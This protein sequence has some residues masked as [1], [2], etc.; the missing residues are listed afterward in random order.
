MQNL[1]VFVA[2]FQ[3]IYKIMRNIFRNVAMLLALSA[4][5]LT[6]SAHCTAGITDDNGDQDRLFNSGWK[7]IRDSIPGAELPGY[8]DSDWEIVDLPHDYSFMDLPGEDSD[9]QIGPFSKKSPGNGNSTGHVIGG[10]GWYRKQF[11]LEKG[12]QDK[13]AVLKFDGVYMES[14]IWVNGEKLYENRNGYTPFLVDITGAL[15]E[16]GE[17]NTIAVKVE[18]KGRNSRWYSG[19]GIYRDVHLLLDH[20]LHVAPWGVYIRTPKVTA[21]TVLAAIQV[22]LQNDFDTDMEVGITI[23]FLDSQDQIVAS[24]EDIVAVPGLGHV[25]TEKELEIKNPILWSLGS[26]YLYTAEITVE[27]DHRVTD[28]YRQPF[29]V[30]TIDISAEHG[31]LLNGEPLLLKGGCL[32]HDNGLLGAAA[33]ERAEARKVELIKASGY[34]AIRIA[35]NPPSEHLLDA[36]DRQGMLVINEFTDMWETYKNPQDYSRFFR[37]DWNKD[38]THMILRDRN[39]PSI[40]MWSIGN[41]ILKNSVADA[42]RIGG[43]LAERVRELDDTRFITEAVSHIFTPEGWDKSGPVFEL[44]DAGGYNYLFDRYEDDHALFPQRIMYAS[45]SFPNKA[46]ETW[47]QVEQHPYVIGD[48]VW[49]AI[50][51]IGEVLVGNSTYVPEEQHAEFSLPENIVL[52]PGFSIWDYM[53]SMPSNWPNYIAWCGDLDITGQ[54]KPQSLFRD[55]LWDSSPIEINVHEPIPEGMAENLSGWGWPKEYPRWY[56][57]GSEGNPLEVRVFTKAHEVRLILNGRI[58]G[59]K[60]LTDQD[61]Y[62]ASFM[63]PYEAGELKAIALENGLEVASKTYTTPGEPVAVSLS[64]DRARITADRSDLAYVLIEVVDEEGRLV[65]DNAL[66]ISLQLSGNGELVG[67]GNASPDGMESVNNPVIR[68]YQGRAQVIIRPYAATGEIRC[69]ASATGLS[70]DEIIILID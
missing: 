58:V 66:T 12:D 68:A 38:L 61:Q 29:G 46:F 37:D 70:G 1:T 41:E 21:G 18:N 62:T 2:H 67:S 15:N 43:Q 69:S 10:T 19:S 63:V 42:L 64:T 30:R 48:F 24:S 16:A 40:I 53:Q 9:E 26:P 55:V 5:W 17:P 39:H 8:D 7:F 49:T 65:P 32:H 50:D 13:T 47:K 54:K 59:E 14:E 60:I 35:H 28:R 25:V 23:N 31:F 34:N 52:P 56:W 22:S 11:V 36:C 44:L 20:P 4:L 45:E 57:P 33:F 51:Y 27:M 6:I 3:Y